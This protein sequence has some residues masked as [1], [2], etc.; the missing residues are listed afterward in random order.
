MSA[1]HKI[2]YIE[3]PARNIEATNAFFEKVCGWSFV[4]YGP[5]YCSFSAE[6]IDGGFYK[7]DLCM[8]SAQGS[9]LIV[10][11]S[12]NLLMSQEQVVPVGPS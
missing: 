6:G 7:S 11:Y 1:H 3:M 9:A 10:L 8:S 12:Q 5:D 2:N 4:D